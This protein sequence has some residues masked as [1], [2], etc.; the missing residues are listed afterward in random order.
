[1]GLTKQQAVRAQIEIAIALYFCGDDPASIYVLG[2]S[3][4]A[5]LAE[6]CKL[7]G[8]ACFDEIAHEWQADRSSSKL[9]AYI[10][11]KRRGR[12]DWYR[13][14]DPEWNSIQLFAVCHD[15]CAAFD[16][17]P[18]V[19]NV[20]VCWFLAIHPEMMMEGFAH[21]QELLSAFNGIESRPKD[22]QLRLGRELLSAFLAQR[23][24]VL[25]L[26]SWR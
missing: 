9:E 24:E 6:A 10:A 26:R 4:G 12:R 11:H 13:Q 20:Y 1:M 15:F 19:L 5:T 25:P 8:A 18:P 23:G 22:E 16:A 14:F 2:R 7:S 21:R 3:A 17:L